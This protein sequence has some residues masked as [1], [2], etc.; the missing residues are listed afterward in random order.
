MGIADAEYKLTYV[1]ANV[2]K[3]FSGQNLDG[4]ERVFNY[5]LSRKCF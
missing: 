4:M 2:L 5:R 3:P 1:K